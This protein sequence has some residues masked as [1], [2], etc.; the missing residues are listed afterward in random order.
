MSFLARLALAAL[1]LTLT[2][3]GLARG[4]NCAPAEIER[5]EK[6]VETIGARI[7]AIDERLSVL[8]TELDGISRDIDLEKSRGGSNPFRYNRLQ[9]LL[10]QSRAKAASMEALSRERGGLERK[11]RRLVESLRACYGDSLDNAL[12]TLLDAVRRR[13]Y[14]RAAE[15]METIKTIESRLAQLSVEESEA[16]YPRIS[17]TFISAALPRESERAFLLDTIRDLLE[18]AERDSTRIRRKLND[19]VKSIRLKRD[20]IALIEE[21]GRGGVEG[22]AF[23][24]EF[25]SEDVQGEIDRLAAEAARLRAA[26]DKTREAAVYYRGRVT[27]VEQLIQ[28][29]RE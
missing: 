14:P 17:E 26:L 5:N 12:V 7:G 11:Q 24:E 13:E 16:V 18:R 10:K 8:S 15:Q 1:G 20:L 28:D 2:V 9:K 19:V 23:F 4:Q 21:A 27:F 22:G 25:N 6:R 29:D 3:S